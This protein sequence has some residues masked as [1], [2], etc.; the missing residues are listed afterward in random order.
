M[1]T[2]Y[3]DTRYDGKLV[4]L[5][6]VIDE[7]YNRALTTIDD[8]LYELLDD[9]DGNEEE[10]Y[11]DYKEAFGHVVEQLKRFHNVED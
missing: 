8:A 6:D 2:F 1:S 7:V 4:R 3:K 5:E 11:M 9:T 10:F